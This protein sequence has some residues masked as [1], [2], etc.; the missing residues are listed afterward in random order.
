M[1]K[2][3]FILIL[4]T[5]VNLS[6]NAQPIIRYPALSPDGKSIAYSYQGDIWV[7]G[8][9]GT[10]PERLTIHEAYEYEPHWS[11]DGQQLV[12]IGNRYGNDD[13]FVVDRQGK[14]V[15]RLTFHSAAD[16]EPAWGKDGQIYFTTNRDFASVEW[17]SEI[18]TIPSGGGTPM[19]RLDALGYQPQLSPDGQM[20][21]FERGS[22]RI[23]REDYHGPANRDIWI[24]HIP[25]KTYHQIT[26]FDG[27]DILPAWGKNNQLYWLSAS[28]GR[29]NLH[30]VM[31][32]N[33]GTAGTTKKITNFKDTGIRYFDVGMA[34]VGVVE[35]G[36]EIL[37]VDLIQ[38]KT[39]PIRI[40]VTGD[41]RFDPV[42]E[43]SFNNSAQEYA[44]SP[45]GKMMA[46]T[47]HGDIFIK[48]VDKDISRT[49]QIT[50]HP[51]RDRNPVWVNDSLLFFLS[52]RDGNY[53]LYSA[54]SS[55]VNQPNPFLSVKHEVRRILQTQVDET[56]LIISP[57]HQK[58]AI[59]QGRGKLV[60]MDVDSTGQL[61]HEVVLQD[62]WDT[63]GGIAWSPDSRW[64]AYALSDLDFNSEV[65]IQPV[66][67]HRKPVNVSMHP[68]DD[69]QPVWSPDGSKLGFLSIRNNGDNDVWFA[70]L[71]KEDWEKSKPDWEG[72]KE[73]ELFADK[74]DKK[75]ESE[76]SKDSLIMDL[77][78]IYERLVQVT[79]FPG[80]EGDLNITKDG[81]TFLFTTNNGGR[82]GSEGDPELLSVKWDGSD[83]KTVLS[84]GRIWSVQ[85]GPNDDY[86]YYF[87]MPGGVS[88]L[89][90]P[91]GKP[92]RL[93]FNAKMSIDVAAER[94]QVFEEA[95]KTLDL[96]FYDPK[97]HGYDW[98]A[99]KKKYK[100][101]ALAA[102]T[103]QDFIYLFNEML[104]QLNSSHMGLFG[105]TPEETQR[106]VTGKLGAEVKPVASGVEVMHVIPNT[107]AAKE[108][109]ALQP[110]D[111][112][113]AVNEQPV[114][115]SNNFYRLLANTANERTLLTVRSPAG[116]NREVIL[117]PANS[118]NTELYEEWVQQRKDLTARYSGGKLG[119]IHIQGM[120]WPSFER[121]EREL[122][123][124]GN[125][126][127]GVVID[128]RYNGGGWTT[129]MLMAVLNVRQHAYTIP[130][131]A[132]ADLKKENTKFRN[133]YPF[134]ERLPLSA[135]TKPSIAMCNESSY[136]NAEIFSHAYKTLGIGKLVGKATFGA[137]ISTGGYGLM[138][139]SFVRLP[140]RAWYVKA[141]GENM[142]HGPAVPDIQVE[143]DPEYKVGDDQQLK[144]A[145]DELLK[146]IN[147]KN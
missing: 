92:E 90:L 38:G 103:K 137:V 11:P 31:I 109:H 78:D 70:W 40:D 104:G 102:S 111:V 100:P 39:T 44:V 57:D 62:G 4:F 76:Q 101:W 36:N 37:R 26:T 113:M 48:A 141:T 9:D 131:G 25:T 94:E 139:G 147:S 33:D 79:H 60:V 74:K 29:Y 110:G 30:S 1:K 122:M 46:L 88:R 89:K 71:R 52:D 125:G 41:D 66:D 6:A 15:R 69:G 118:I 142:E 116:D 87:G 49:T 64:L 91:D 84:N 144:A 127:E 17:E 32:N 19:R 50:H 28:S 143:N 14:S 124:S 3:Q 112:I 27:Q 117:R 106:E 145:V 123:A 114:N 59:V 97:F 21:A 140:F 99:L 58:L 134:S 115:A 135:W 13:L 77:D 16:R 2:F 72:D 146:E 108:D 95:W 136:S 83:Q 63:P 24:Y 47:I 45:N 54:R 61:S 107:P 121:F 35:R 105:S 81:E 120:N 133:H 22:C 23:T 80:N 12:F 56:E 55:D 85:P 7:A 129:D 51:Y 5:C 93:P 98:D 126:K 34:D 119:Y 53:E 82:A 138:D 68:R 128:V 86:L 75:K 65:Y 96:G 130:R 8:I 18:H 42:V 132:A 43:Q 20:I 73:N 10:H 67:N